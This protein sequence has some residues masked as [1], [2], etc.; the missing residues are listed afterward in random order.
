MVEA[1]KKYTARKIVAD[2]ERH[3]R[4]RGLAEGVRLSTAP[5]MAE[6]FGVSV[7]T[8]HR[9]VG[10][11]V[12]KGLVYR[13]RGSGTY[14]SNRGAAVGGLRVGLFLWQQQSGSPVLDQ[15]AFGDYTDVLMEK[16]EERGH[17]VELILERISNK[18]GCVLN[19]MELEKFDVII[20]AAGF[21]EVA[22]AR[23]RAFRGE[24]IL[25][26][27]DISHPGPWHQVVYD[28]RPG[29]CHALEYLRSLGV[30][31]IFVP[32]ATGVEVCVR[33][34][35]ALLE[36]ALRLDF[37]AEDSEFREVDCGSL[38]RMVMAGRDCG[39]Y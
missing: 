16:I 23:L 1:R 37:R 13:V 25:I 5:L 6:R 19:R 29:F 34:F 8:V 21:L 18:S 27:D 22:E 4:E 31:K 17:C 10:H 7:K 15:V 33:R 12:D 30:R 2:L 35:R 11:L 26:N 24:L 38:S 14:V 28:Y 36:E 3:I 32:G 20:A 9:A 39:K